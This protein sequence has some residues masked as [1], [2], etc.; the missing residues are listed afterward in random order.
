MHK[1]IE[2]VFAACRM[3]WNMSEES[4]V[5]VVVDS[6]QFTIFI[7]STNSNRVIEMIDRQARRFSNNSLNDV[8]ESKRSDA[9]SEQQ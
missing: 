3:T 6:L 1:R 2:N 9:L 7:G 8:N 4:F 5:V